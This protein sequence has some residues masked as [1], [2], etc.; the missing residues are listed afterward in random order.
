MLAT[1]MASNFDYPTIPPP[2]FAHKEFRR[3]YLR[4]WLCNSSSCRDPKDAFVKRFI[5]IDIEI[6]L[7]C[8]ILEL[9]RLGI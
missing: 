7:R 6:D 4:V 5:G 1:K 9:K 3:K 8:Q 2:S